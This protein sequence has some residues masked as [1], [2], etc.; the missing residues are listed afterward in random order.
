MLHGVGEL[1]VR[2][3][4]E[5]I[6]SSSDNTSADWR[7]IRNP[8]AMQ[9]A[10]LLRLMRLRSLV[11]L[12]ALIQFVGCTANV[13]QPGPAIEQPRQTTNTFV[14]SDGSKLPYRIWRAGGEPLA[15][16][17]ALHGMNDSR[18]AWEYPAPELAAHGITVIAPDQRGFGETKDR[19]HWP[20]TQALVTDAQ[21]MVT[22]V[23]QQY[24][25]T[26]LILMGESMGA[27]V[28]MCLAASGRPLPVDGYILV[29]PAVWGRAEMGLFLRS[30][31]WIATGLVPGLEVS[32]SIARRVASDNRQ[33]IR[34]LASD[35]L[36]IT[37]TRVD[38]IAGL[39]DL[40]DAALNA[41]PNFHGRAIVLYG[42]KDEMIPARATLAAWRALPP[43]VMRAY[44]P[45]SYH[46]LLRDLGRMTPIDDILAWILR[47]ADPLPSCADRAAAA[48]LS[49]Q[50]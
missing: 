25:R 38:A 17:L 5:I 35:P 31:L 43:G 28:L 47:P 33:A 29:A 16:I 18:D 24:P 19:G 2:T 4:V 30:F 34:R 42:G 8:I 39:V 10:S 26:R 14:M 45:E 3:T 46:L 12:V 41:A 37:A 7:P 20:G 44:Y 6:R 40:M 15:V 22:M 50:S 1:L 21:E 48:W 23:R 13:V 32:G 49:N 27:A 9:R 11:G 36:T